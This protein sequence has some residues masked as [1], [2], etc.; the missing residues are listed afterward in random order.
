MYLKP[1]LSAF[2][3]DPKAAA[4]SLQ[5]LLHKAE[6]VVPA[7][8]RQ[9]TLVKVGVNGYYF[10]SNTFV[11]CKIHMLIYPIHIS[12]VILLYFVMVIIPLSSKHLLHQSLQLFLNLQ[13]LPSS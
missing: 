6:V 2:A 4:G 1:C 13:G 5:P 3:S 12:L 11:F 9:N 10:S 7:N 8:K